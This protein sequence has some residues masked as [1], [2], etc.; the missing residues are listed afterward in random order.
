MAF[1]RSLWV[2]VL[3]RLYGFCAGIGRVDGGIRLFGGGGIVT[4]MFGC[5]RVWNVRR[6]R[7]VGLCL[8]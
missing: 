5:G 6:S 2:V 4:V 8:T 1:A 7:P 3:N